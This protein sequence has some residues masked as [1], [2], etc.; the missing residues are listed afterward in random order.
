MASTKAHHATGW[1]AGL[2]AA[3]LAA[4]AGNTG[5]Y[6]LWTALTFLAGMA[7]AT[8]P[9]WMEVAWW[10]RTQRLWVTHRTVTHWGV[11]WIGMAW[12]S[13]T[14]LAR[15]PMAAPLFGFACG[16]IIH[17]LADWPNPRGV[18][19]LWH[20][21]SLKLWKSGRCDWIIVGAAWMGAAAVA[22]HVWFHGLHSRWLVHYVKNGGWWA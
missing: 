18:P 2:C 15:Q 5:P 1:A 6:F 17:L 10:S 3:A 22:D 14:E 13:W 12:W 21:H 7:G 20:R 16:G 4:Q 19:W 11:G 8:A 9:D